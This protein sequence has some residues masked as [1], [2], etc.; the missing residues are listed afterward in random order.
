MDICIYP[1]ST[2]YHRNAFYCRQ[3]QPYI[4]KILFSSQKFPKCLIF[5]QSTNLSSILSI[6]VN[7]D[8]SSSFIAFIVLSFNP[9]EILDLLGTKKA[10]LKVEKLRQQ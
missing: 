7:F 1:N 6:D 5:F 10:M 3:S 4:V 9:D 8:I 2:L